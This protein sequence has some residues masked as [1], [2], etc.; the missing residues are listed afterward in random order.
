VDRLRH[1]HQ[2]KEAYTGKR[3]IRIYNEDCSEYLQERLIRTRP[4]SG[5]A[6]GARWCFSSRSGCTCLGPPLRGS[7]PRAASNLRVL[8][9]IRVHPADLDAFI[10]ARLRRRQ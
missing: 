6:D 2:I 8:H 1:L 10:G 3:E 9:A 5:G 7:P 4:W